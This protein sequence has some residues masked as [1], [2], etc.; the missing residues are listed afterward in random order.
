MENSNTGKQF[1]DEIRDTGNA[2]KKGQ[3]MKNGTTEQESKHREEKEYKRGGI[4]LSALTYGNE[5]WTAV[6]PSEVQATEMNYLR[7]TSAGT[8]MNGVGDEER[9]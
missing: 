4:I 3:T 8:K 9:L 1:E 5:V 7:A 6:E 2:E